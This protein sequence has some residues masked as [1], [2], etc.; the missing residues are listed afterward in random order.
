MSYAQ[1]GT[2][3]VVARLFADDYIGTYMDIGAHHPI[4]MSNTY[5]FYT[6]GWRGVTVEPTLVNRDLH[7]RLRPRDMQLRY[8]VS[9]RDGEAD[10]YVCTET[11]VSTIDQAE[12]SLR[13]AA[14]QHAEVERVVT[15]TVRSIVQGLACHSHLGEGRIY[16][17]GKVPD[18]LSI[19]VEGH[20][21]AVLEG[22]PFDAGWLPKV[23][24]LEACRPCTDVPCHEDW[25]DIL[26]KYQYDLYDVAGVNRVYRTGGSC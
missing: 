9:N 14:G 13:V 2:D 21:R 8:A 17:F 26:L 11:S 4:V 25:E 19:D 1:F 15:K 10:F 12:A 7:A 16:W 6:R 24:V 5:L 23:V 20:E 3:T 18:L 22:C